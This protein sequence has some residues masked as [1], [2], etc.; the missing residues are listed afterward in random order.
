MHIERVIE[1]HQNGERWVH[2]AALEQTHIAHLDVGAFRELFL[3]ERTPSAEAANVRAIKALKRF[4][5]LLAM[6]GALSRG[7]RPWSS[8][9]WLFVLP[10]RT[11]RSNTQCLVW[12]ARP[13]DLP[14]RRLRRQ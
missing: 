2:L 13:N 8:Q 5:R 4:D 7:R 14:A 12:D 11:P 1:R 6:S 9:H 10:L 3:R